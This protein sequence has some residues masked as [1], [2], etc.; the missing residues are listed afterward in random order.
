MIALLGGGLAAVVLGSWFAFELLGGGDRLRRDGVCRTAEV[1]V[2]YEFRIARLGRFA[3]VSFVADGRIH[4]ALIGYDGQRRMPA[5]QP[6]AICSEPDDPEVLTLEG[7]EWV[8]DSFGRW[9][10]GN[11]GALALIMGGTVALSIG[12]GS[13]MSG[14]G[15]PTTYRPR[16]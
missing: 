15:G 7:D 14:G 1:S 11:V 3:E 16:H 12:F 9:L 13:Y 4:Q 8:G 10:R 5:G 6:V 2:S